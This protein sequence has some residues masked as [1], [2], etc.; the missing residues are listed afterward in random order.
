MTRVFSGIQ[1][2]GELHVGN[3]LGAV[4]NWVRLQHQ[5]DCLFCIVDLHAV[6]Q[7]YD[8]ATL[9]QRTLDMAVGLLAAGLD[10]ERCIVVLQSHVAEHAELNWLLTTVTPLGEL[11]RQTRSEERRV[12]KECRTRWWV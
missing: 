9:R 7:P 2:S 1:P 4:Q 3:Y 8:V 12:G 5:H 11:E 6:T 10:P